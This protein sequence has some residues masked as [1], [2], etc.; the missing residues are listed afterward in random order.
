L[1]L[2]VQKGTLHQKIN[3]VLLSPE[4]HWIEHNLNLLTENYRA[5]PFFDKYFQKIREIYCSGFSRMVDLN[6]AFLQFSFEIFDI[7]VD[8]ILAS[9]VNVASRSSER[10]IN[11][12][13]AVHGTHY[14]TGIG[15][16][17]YLD[18]EMFLKEKITVEW[19]VFVHPVY[20]QLHG[21]FIPG[22]SWLDLLFNCGPSAKD[23]LRSCLIEK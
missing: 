19:Q 5:A 4:W 7:Q 17:D 23:V 6:L 11:L 13:K 9:E 3:E 20:P 2:S 1:T 16:R 18:E 14:L 8:T 12:I 22:L 10:L 21:S 15:S